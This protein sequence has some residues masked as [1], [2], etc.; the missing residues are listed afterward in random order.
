MSDDRPSD[1]DRARSTRRP[2]PPRPRRVRNTSPLLPQLLAAAVELDPSHTALV[3][4]DIEL[5]YAELDRR[6]SRI[7]RVLI[8]SGIGPESVVA[9]GITRSIESVLSVWSVAKTGAAFLPVDPTYPADRVQHMISDSGARVGLTTSK[10]RDSLPDECVWTVLDDARFQ[11]ELDCVSDE[12]ISVSDRTAVLRSDNP[13]YLIYTSGST[14]LP[15]GVV[16]THR[17]LAD[18]TAAQKADYGLT[19]QART[20]HFA[21][22]S[23]DASVLELSM[24]VAA[25]STMVVAPTDIYGGAELGAFLRRNRITHAF[26]TPAAL[27]S[28]EPVD[29]DDLVAVVVGGESCP[30][31]LVEA[32]APGRSFFNAYG[33]TESTVAST[34]SPALRPGDPVVIGKAIVGTTAH[35]LDRRLRPVPTG[36]AGE[37]YLDGAGLAR[38]YESR[39]GLTSSRFVANPSADQGTRMYRT[40]DVVRV[41]ASGALEY[42]ARNDFQVK[43]RGFRIE[44]G[45]IDT[46]LCSHDAV[47]FAVTV[48][49][50]GPTGDTALVSYVR[51][52]VGHEIDAAELTA[53]AGGVLP[54][55]MV[56]ASIMQID[57]VPLT[58]SGKLDRDA[59]PEPVF[60]SREY[61]SPETASERAVA[62]VFSTILGIEQVGLD[63]DFFE[64]GGNSLSATRL[65]ARIGAATDVNIAA[66]EVF[67]DSTVAGLARAVDAKAGAARRI[68][69][70]E[71]P[72]PD[73][74]PVSLAQQR[75]WFLN[76]FDAES[77]AY[78][79]P[80][81][82][83]LS[84]ALDV[85]ALRAA[86]DDVVGRHEPL[87]TLYPEDESG[88]VQKILPAAQAGVDLEVV[89]VDPGEI[90]SVVRALAATSFDVTAQVP[91][92]VRLY[93]LSETEYVLALVVQHI[94]ADGGS[95]GP[96]TRDVMVAYGAQSAGGVPGWAP[97][98]V[99]YADFAI[100][101]R[102]VLGS[103][104]DPRS[105][106][107]EQL[108]FWK[109]ELA[110]LPD[111]LELPTDR[112][113]PAVQSFAG[114]KIDFSMNASVQESLSAAARS[115][116]ATLFMAVHAAWASVLARLS[117]SVDIAVGSPIAGRGEAALD[118]LI[119][120]F[121]NT[122]VFRTEVDPSASFERTLAAVREV[123]VRSL[124]HADVPFERLVEVLNPA[125]STARHP[126][127]QVGLSFQNIEKAV[128]ELPGLSVSAVDAD[129]E[130]AQFDLHLIV[131]D[132]YD[133]D[134]N[135]TGMGATLKYA[136]ALFDEDTARSIVDR[137]VAFVTAVASDP[138][139]VVGDVDI[140]GAS[141]RELTV[142][143]WNETAHEIDS[144]ATLVAAVDS[145][146][147]GRRDA[148]AL[149]FGD[150]S[151]SYR[152]FDE[153]VNRLA[154]YLISCG[155]GPES[156]VA[157]AIRRSEVMVWAMFAVVK[158]GG[159][160]V[161]V[162]P[163]QPADRVG[164]IV[165]S[166]APVVVL[167]AG[168]DGAEFAGASIPAGQRVVDIEDLDLG[169]VD[170]TAVTDED[171]AV[172][173]RPDNTAYVI[174]TSGSTGRP[175]GVAVSHRSVIN[176]LE[177]MRA[178]YE[179]DESDV[180][181]LKTAATFDLSVWELWSWVVVGGR[182][183][184]ATADGHRDPVYLSTLVQHE[185]VT[186]LHVVPSVLAAMVE[187]SGGA[188]PSSIRRVLAI[189]EAL[190][191]STARTVLGGGNLRLDNVYGPT[192]AAVSVT[193]IQ[194]EL[195]IDSVVPI[196]RPE[197]NC[198][199][200]VL[201]SRL[202]P[203]PVG[204]V[205]ELYLSGVQLARGYQGRFDLTADR[206]V[207]DPAGSGERMYR[208]GDLVR[209]RA[210]GVLDY[211]GRSDFQ[212]KIRGFRIELGEIESVV[213]GAPGVRDVAVLARSDERLGDR[214]VAY[215]VGSSGDVDPGAVKAAVA[216]RLP[217]YMIPAAFVVL[218]E[219]PR[220]VNGKLD[221]AAL[222]EPEMEVR[223]FRAPTSPT[224]QT[225]ADVFADVLGVEQVG[226]DDDFF[227]LGGN[228]LV[229]TQIV[230][231]LSTAVGFQ[232][233]LLWMFSG[234]TV[235]ALA[236]RIDEGPAVTD[237]RTA[238]DV[239]LPI[240]PSSSGRR[241]WCFHPIVGVSWSFGGLAQTLASDIG[242]TALQSPALTEPEW[243]PR[244]IADWADR[245]VDEIRRVQPEGPYELLGWSL[246]GVLAHAVAVRLQKQGSTVRLLA[247][248]DSALGGSEE[249]ADVAA[250][251]TPV[252]MSHLFGALLPDATFDGSDVTAESIAA[253]VAT[254]PA[255]FSEISAERIADVVSGAEE[256]RSLLAG[257]VPEVFDGDVVY[258]TA[259][260]DDPTGRV[261]A[262]GWQP[263][264]TGRVDN[265]VVEE[266]HWRMASARALAIVS[267]VVNSS[268]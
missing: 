238:L 35:V 27:A 224:A 118:D 234:S 44:L 150:R 113:R 50:P 180:F 268:K 250:R 228:S 251:A 183:V 51:P 261:G 8:S 62:A 172:P 40:G 38:G 258:F 167:I 29:L 191:A 209:W 59:L 61:R 168:G 123:D 110:G 32:W 182:L 164:Y 30:P 146:V 34:I 68:A 193:S 99:Q 235:D 207:A 194:L 157:V 83:R 132:Q 69:L 264:L 210:D 3:A 79:I 10:F 100:W 89:D 23:F 73:R 39:P 139:V 160:Y 244:S 203:V 260:V 215:V 233:P 256:A 9:I 57:T 31:E 149:T 126:L 237:A 95:M 181:L 158:A 65:A 122:L 156:T 60:A 195:P 5:S 184:I 90:V 4:G 97:L 82:I 252:T 189:G 111:Q 223:E 46:A 129:A 24:A 22:P 93:R 151:W 230:A 243:A 162:D 45:E 107:F 166:A 91:V 103:E 225:V 115:S 33:P 212:V 169:G 248:M 246:G 96:L 143:T 190:P 161:P 74:I 214:L 226:L 25:G 153:R 198:R 240:R 199:V 117:G 159:A 219:L 213:A 21:S 109:Q 127:F 178:E 119:G 192:E 175:K 186:T 176:Q 144:G 85:D 249:A 80:V 1:V 247:M 177:W 254:L 236:R 188:L 19:S 78:N 94:S 28:V 179:L 138:S 124:A 81:A 12:R 222:P 259:G 262:D 229:A 163:D 55:H 11:T 136:T 255:P 37:L 2:R 88:P 43:V 196:G 165:G 170:A 13:A 185:A 52:V 120:M 87:R 231:R 20:L 112:P 47:A 187:A 220:N 173:L 142:V 232:V 206:F 227:E 6:S 197:W 130:V 26:V 49:V 41:T 54:K 263:F 14:G 53:F 208:T 205:G 266:T 36:V 15:K 131:S 104:D 121:A 114:G 265:Q 134:G 202:H 141:E 155:V 108:S 63:D 140:M 125:R 58:P 66:G 16:V 133:E 241:L 201:D 17:G 211:I 216:E 257:H 105:I 64:L 77:A 253:A 67:Q 200:A 137:F 84:G 56:P 18:L 102:E 70:G 267:K 106:A 75:M 221:R 171:R 76:R 239:V 135:A 48:G 245:Y 98:E 218:D 147:S 42:L 71:L 86:I 242:I 92:R 154:R 7:A 204:V 72:R 128:L 148:I 152:E 217:S 101:Q 145:A 116:N 174:F